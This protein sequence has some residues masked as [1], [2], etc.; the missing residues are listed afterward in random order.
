MTRCCN[1]RQQISVCDD[2]FLGALGITIICARSSCFRMK[3]KVDNP[4]EVKTNSELLIQKV[5]QFTQ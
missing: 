3:C 2:L 5:S 1:P 4:Y